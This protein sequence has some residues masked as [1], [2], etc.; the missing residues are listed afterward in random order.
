MLITWSTHVDKSWL[1]SHLNELCE[2]WEPIGITIAHENP[3]KEVSYYHTHCVLRLSKPLRKQGEDASHFFCL[4]CSFEL[5]VG[6]CSTCPNHLHPHVKT[7]MG[8]GTK[9]WIDALG[10]ISKQD[11]V[12]RKEAE[13]VIESIGERQRPIAETIVT[14]E[15]HEAMRYLGDATEQTI[16]SRR[17]VI[18]SGLFEYLTKANKLPPVV[19]PLVYDW[20]KQLATWVRNNE[21]STDRGI[22]VIHDKYGGSGKTK[23]CQWAECS[24][25]LG[26]T[27]KVLWITHTGRASDMLNIIGTEYA[28]NGWDCSVMLISIPRDA[29]EWSGLF[30][31]IE[32][33]K[34]GLLVCTKYQSRK[35]RI[36]KNPVI[37]LFCNAMPD[38]SKL[39]DDRW[40]VYDVDRSVLDHN[41]PGITQEYLD[42]VSSTCHVNMPDSWNFG[43][44]GPFRRNCVNEPSAPWRRYDYVVRP[45][46]L[47]DAK[48]IRDRER[49][50]FLSQQ[51]R[52]GDV[53]PAF[54]AL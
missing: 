32:Q 35:I 40:Q 21:A 18:E 5:T 53:V 28:H 10:Y 38:F 44:M 33:L 51:S 13:K 37:V 8:R 54:T 36:P 3:D 30:H 14:Y 16:M 49:G 41:H 29:G 43:D 22:H 15:P 24:A 7:L 9:S 26:D 11:P 46:S 1:T 4:P 48:D 52:P 47:A 50:L 12:A 6:K 39:S 27:Y 45:I 25:N 17:A 19:A 42:A 23:F 31:Y 20:Q 34:D 2:E